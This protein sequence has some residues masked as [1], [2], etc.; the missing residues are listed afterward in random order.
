MRHRTKFFIF[1]VKLTYGKL[2][3]YVEQRPADIRL[4]K[5]LATL[6]KRNAQTCKVFEV[7]ID[8]SSLSKKS[9][10]HLNDLFVEAKWFY[11]YCLGLPNVNDSNTTAKQVPVKVKDVFEDRKLSVLGSQMKQSLKTRLF[12]SLSSL[13]S[14]KANGRKVGRLKFKSKLDSIPLKQYEVTYDID[15][16]KKRIRLQGLKQ[17]LKA[18]GLGQLQDLEIANAVLVRKPSGYYLNVT[19]FGPQRGQSCTRR[20]RR[21]RLWLSNTINFF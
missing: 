19:T 5:R 3:N 20:L 12:N 4:A 15:L 18:R 7:K 2:Y 8:T 14:L 17:W 10:K 21:D 9:R 11:N 6:A 16:N 1:I 13:H